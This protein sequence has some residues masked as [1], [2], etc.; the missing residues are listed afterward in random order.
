MEKRKLIQCPLCGEINKQDITPQM[1]LQFSRANGGL[2]PIL[3]NFDSCDHKFI[4]YMDRYYMVR[5]FI[6]VKNEEDIPFLLQNENPTKFPV[7]LFDLWGKCVFV[8]ESQ[9]TQNPNKEKLR[10]K[11]NLE[12]NPIN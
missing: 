11:S 8:Y 4:V 9:S 12:I 1:N 2:I 3:I 6:Y 7:N 10:K 5:G